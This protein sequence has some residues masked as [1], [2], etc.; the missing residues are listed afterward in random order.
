MQKFL[1]DILIDP[2]DGNP[3]I[4]DQDKNIL[5]SKENENC[6]QMVISPIVKTSFIIDQKLSLSDNNK[7]REQLEQDLYEL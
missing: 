2:E 7:T 4:T 6:T 1:T 5:Y 3:L